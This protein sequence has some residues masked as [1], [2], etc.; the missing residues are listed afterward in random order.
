LFGSLTDVCCF[1]F[2]GVFAKLRTDSSCPSV[3]PHGKPRL[4]Q[5]GYHAIWYLS[6]FGKSSE[7][8]QLSLKSDKNR[9]YCAWRRMYIVDDIAH[10][11]ACFRQRCV[12]NRSTHFVL[13]I[14]FLENRAVYEIMWENT[15]ESESHRWS[16][17]FHAGYLR[18]QTHT[19]NI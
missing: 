9:R 6:I 8:I 7:K 17:T 4:L 13:S 15:V 3:C 16:G 14:C 5:E 1:Q 10:I 19:H 12:E 11:S 2:L 18:L